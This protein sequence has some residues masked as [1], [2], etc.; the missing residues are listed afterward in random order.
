MQEALKHKG[1]VWGIYRDKEL[2]GYYIFVREDVLLSDLLG[3]EKT[4]EEETIEGKTNKP[5]PIYRLCNEYVGEI[6]EK[7]L[8]FLEKNLQEQLKEILQWGT[9]K[10]VI[11]DDKTMTVDTANQNGT[12]MGLWIP[13]GMM[14][15]VSFGTI[16]DNLAM[17]IS[18][19]LL[20]GVVF[21]NIFSSG[22]NKKN[23]E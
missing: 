9:I 5:E 4:N 7:E 20:W 15:G 13:I 8:T 2:Q 3:E 6:D 22:A 16:F 1:K 17:G 18:L 23:K 10:A 19:G 14:M 12:G 21:G 11:W